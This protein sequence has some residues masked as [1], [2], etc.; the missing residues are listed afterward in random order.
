M[1]SENK[2]M[3]GWEALALVGIKKVEVREGNT[4]NGNIKAD[5]KGGR[6]RKKCREGNNRMM[7]ELKKLDS[8]INYGVREPF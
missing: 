2:R 8:S 4:I 1:P 6:N 3:E 5:G 7:R